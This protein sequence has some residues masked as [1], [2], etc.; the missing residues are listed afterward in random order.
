MEVNVPFGHP[1][2]VGDEMTVRSRVARDEEARRDGGGLAAT[3][4]MPRANLPDPQAVADAR[5]VGRLPDAQLQRMAESIQGSLG[6]QGAAALFGGVQRAPAASK[7]EP[8][9]GSNQ[10]TIQIL[11]ARLVE[12]PSFI[13]HTVAVL[14]R[15]DLVTLTGE[16][17]GGWHRV[18]TPDG[19]V[20][21]LHQSAW[22]TST[23]KLSSAPGAGGGTEPREEIEIGGRG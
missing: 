15:G 19:A 6:N 10:V 18:V 12:K 20:G 3:S 13:A 8:A 7:P 16:R 23:P 5:L 4:R 1:G 9:A 22:Q 14:S 17:K 2:E 21:W 11:T